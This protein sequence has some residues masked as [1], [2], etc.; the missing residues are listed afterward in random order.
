MSRIQEIKEK[1][2]LNL[3]SQKLRW[4]I[5]VTAILILI[6]GAA[7][8]YYAYWHYQQPKF[9]DVTI[10]LGTKDLSIDAFYTK[11]VH[12]QNTSF[13]TA[14][15]DIDYS[16]IGEQSIVLK[17]GKKEESVHLIIQDTTPPVAEFR[18]LRVAINSKVSAEDFV[19]SY[20]DLSEVTI[21]FVKPLAAPE[22]YDEVVVGVSVTDSGGNT[23][24]GQC[25]LSYA[26]IREELTVEL[27]LEITK[28]D[29]LYDPVTD[30][31]LLNQDVLDQINASPVGEYE[32]ECKRGSKTL[33]CKVN[34]VDT[35]GPELTLHPVQIYKG[36][37]AKIESFVEKA[38]DLSGDVTLEYITEPDFS[39]TGTQTV[40]ITATDSFGNQTTAETT[41]D[42][43]IDKTPPVITLVGDSTTY[44]Y[45]GDT[46]KEQ[47]ATAI[48]ACDGD[49][50]SKIKISGSVDTSKTGTY[51][52]EYTVADAHNNQATAKRTV[53]VV[54]KPTPQPDNP[55]PASGKVVYLTF[56]DGPGPYT[57]QLLDILDKYNVKA[58]FFVVNHPRYN[59]LI[60]EESRRG[61]SVAI[62]SYSHDYSKI[63]KSDSAY[64]DDLYAMQE[65]IKAQTG[66][67][68]SLIRF[69]GGSSNTVSRS[70]NKGI[71]RRLTAKVQEL[72]FVYFDWNV[73]S[74]DAGETTKTS[75]VAQNV[76]NG[77]KSHNTSI[78]LQHDIKSF[79]VAAVEQIIVWGLDNGYT[80]LPL[81]TSSPAVHHGVNN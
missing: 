54:K 51:T 75:V 53:K 23:T 55:Q 36:K 12:S 45:I 3:N 15:E 69:P 17:S 46:Y 33:I 7:G 43:Q 44:I 20:E 5:I 19:V 11:Y 38:S 71:M 22:D 78:V 31:A 59:Y 80:F 13:V 21:D 76:I 29:I 47:G 30:D 32:V 1:N 14:P 77:M 56:D 42:I 64:L 58:T 66:H 52:I 27:G 24:V 35:T 6:G 16:H 68:T 37:T 9:H 49:V 28:E 26:W 61:H 34:V 18:D 10:E 74:G 2:F 73:T 41:L 81:T 25:K 63:Y 40:Q 65:V 70:Y 50:S 79:S 8:G 62:H 72:G 60:A 4:A 39:V 57:A 67:E 48:D